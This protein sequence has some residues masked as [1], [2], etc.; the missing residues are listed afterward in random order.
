MHENPKTYFSSD[1]YWNIL[2]MSIA[3]NIDGIIKIL[4][5]PNEYVDT[6]DCET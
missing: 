4:E 3:L 1:N 6:E 5:K 2:K